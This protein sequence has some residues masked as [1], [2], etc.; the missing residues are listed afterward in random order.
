METIAEPGLTILH[1][2]NSNANMKSNGLS[3][4]LFIFALECVFMKVPANQKALKLNG[5]YQFLVQADD[6]NILGGNKHTIMKGTKALVVANKVTGMEQNSE[7]TAYHV[8][9]H[10]SRPE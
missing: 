6:V 2:K 8:Y 4:L 9:G 7:K 1:L 5:V 10:V 3:P